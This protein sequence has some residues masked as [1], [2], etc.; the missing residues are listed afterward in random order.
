MSRRS[1]R[2]QTPRAPAP[3][4][5]PRPPTGVS[6]DGIRPARHLPLRPHGRHA[7]A[8]VHRH[9][10]AQAGRGALHV[11]QVLLMRLLPACAAATTATAAAATRASRRVPLREERPRRQHQARL[12]AVVQAQGLYG[13]VQVHV[14][15]AL[16]VRWRATSCCYGLPRFGFGLPSALEGSAQGS[17]KY[18]RYV[19]FRAFSPP[20]ASARPALC[21]CRRRRRRRRPCRRRHHPPRPSWRATP[22]STAT[23][24]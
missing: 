21:A 7:Q 11:V 8:P 15:R 16:A 5:L 1:L 17:R 10:P 12:L 22:A 4:C 24:A 6:T 14:E 20:G 9:V 23:R 19:R 18:R 13:L 2:I 3:R